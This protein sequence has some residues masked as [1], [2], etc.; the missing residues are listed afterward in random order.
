[1]EIA[2][3]QEQARVPVT[4]IRVVGPIISERELVEQA[5][6]AYENG[7]RDILLDLTDV[8]YISSQGLRALHQMYTMLRTDAP[9]ESDEAVRQGIRAGTFSSP[10]LKLLNPSEKVAEVL[11]IT[12]YDMFL[13]SFHD[14]RTALAAFGPPA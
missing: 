1:M 4:V 2:I 10:H 14:R 7:A 9:N 11:H 8:P 12:G 5:R 6:L 3:S 13:E